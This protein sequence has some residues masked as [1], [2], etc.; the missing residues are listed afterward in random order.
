MRPGSSLVDGS[1]TNM[2]RATITAHLLRCLLAPPC[3]VAGPRLSR[4]SSAPSIWTLLVGLFPSWMVPLSICA[5]FAASLS[6]VAPGV[7]YGQQGD[8]N[9]G[10]AVY[11]LKCL[12][13]HGEKGD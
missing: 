4:R 12:L 5:S 10:K 7:A 2:W 1:P 6:L 3:D 13:C 9:A 11:E 8:A